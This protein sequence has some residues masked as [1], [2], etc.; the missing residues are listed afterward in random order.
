M[1]MALLSEHNYEAVSEHG[2]TFSQRPRVYEHGDAPV[3]VFDVDLLDTD[4]IDPMYFEVNAEDLRHPLAP[5]LHPERD[6]PDGSYLRTLCVHGGKLVGGST[7]GVLVV[8]C[9][10]TL[11][12]PRAT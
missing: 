9:L 1:A 6:W 3:V 2:F 5:Y 10:A 8:A 12:G 7:R 11:L 4:P